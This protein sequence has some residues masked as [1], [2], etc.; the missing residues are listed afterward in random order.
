MA[1]CELL[2]STPPASSTPHVF[3]QGMTPQFNRAHLGK[4][5]LAEH[6]SCRTHPGHGPEKTGLVAG[7][8]RLLA[9][10]PC[11]WQSPGQGGSQTQLQPWQG[12]WT[13]MAKGFHIR[14]VRSMPS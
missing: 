13:E 6:T 3:A 11:H 10:Q 4:Q 12:C 2:L 1:G 5:P 9:E 7:L 8:R 14:S